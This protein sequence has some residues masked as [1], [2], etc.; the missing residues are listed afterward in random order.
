MD[1]EEIKPKIKNLPRE[2]G[3]QKRKMYAYE[4]VYTSYEDYHPK[5]K[6]LKKFKKNSLKNS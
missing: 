5:K 2:N 6:S 1:E 4:E 3:K